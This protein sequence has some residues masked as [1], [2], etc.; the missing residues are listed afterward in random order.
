MG[1]DARRVNLRGETKSS[2]LKWSVASVSV[3]IALT[4]RHH[5]PAA[6]LLFSS[7]E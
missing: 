1:G 3:H 6:Y 4:N 2:Q 7:L 5:R